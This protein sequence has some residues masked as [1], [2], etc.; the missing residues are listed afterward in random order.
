M[1]KKLNF[2]HTTCIYNML[3]NNT[4]HGAIVFHVFEM[5]TFFYLR[6]RCV[7]FL[8]F[9]CSKIVFFTSFLSCVPSLYKN[10]YLQTRKI[11]FFVRIT[12][13]EDGLLWY[14]LQESSIC[15]YTYYLHPRQ[16]LLI[17][18]KVDCSGCWWFIEYFRLIYCN[19]CQ[20]LYDVLY[21]IISI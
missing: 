7:P 2:F 6:L 20:R 9:P 19:N 1:R 11:S 21:Y 17:Y 16:L 13:L 8:V 5:C 14:L 18:F 3:I 12:L 4:I 10:A 15:I